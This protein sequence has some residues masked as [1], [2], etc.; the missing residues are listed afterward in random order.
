MKCNMS[1]FRRHI[2]IFIFVLVSVFAGAFQTHA[3]SG[4]QKAKGEVDW[5]IL[6][7]AQA[8]NSLSTFAYKNFNDMATAGSN[9]DVNVVVQ[10][11]KAGEPGTF[12]YRI[13]NGRLEL[14]ECLKAPTD[15]NKSE[16][17]V[18]AMRWAVSKYPAKKYCLVLWNHGI[19]ILDPAWGNSVM[20]VSPRFIDNNPRIQ[21]AGV[22]E[23]D[24]GILADDNMFDISI[25]ATRNTSNL[26]GAFS[27]TDLYRSN[28]ELYS[29]AEH[30]GILFNER[31]RT[32]MNNQSLS[33]ALSII[34]T[35]VLKNKKIDV[36][37]MD[38]CLMAMVEVGY[39][40]KDYAQYMVA[41]QEVELAYGWNYKMLLQAFGINKLTPL[42][43]AQSIVLVYEELYKK[44]IQFYTQSAMKLENSNLLKISID[45]VARDILSCCDLDFN[46]FTQVVKMARNKC[47]SF[48][49]PT[50]IDAHSFFHELDSLIVSLYE[51]SQSSKNLGK[52]KTATDKLKISLKTAQD[53]IEDTVVA[54][55][56][57]KYY[58]KA[59]GLSI[60]YPSKAISKSYASTDFA[61]DSVWYSFL[62]QAVYW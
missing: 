50:Y 12:R 10:W 29:V 43:V 55:V 24:T 46:G 30:R 44:Q 15:G 11:Y 39:Q 26:G 40:V 45:N 53:V 41:S 35:D 33:K 8:N 31:S 56:S 6:I 16:D 17:L 4:V 13:E 32:Y 22:T 60:Y 2:S 9:K 27:D 61:R 36:L 21:I 18:G 5:T 23:A 25:N 7:Y 58:L 14:D 49:T 38:A 20:M 62:Q 42:E 47:V 3:S 28:T 57:G 59:K 1:A 48:S 52:T 51:K 37:G 19:G 34:K 54:Q